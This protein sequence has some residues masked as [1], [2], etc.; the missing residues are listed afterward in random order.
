M[1]L[2]KEVSILIESMDQRRRSSEKKRQNLKKK[3]DNEKIK[4]SAKKNA[5]NISPFIKKT[6]NKSNPEEENKKKLIQVKK[7][8]YKFTHFDDEDEDW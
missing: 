5:N 2:S 3:L 8:K 6:Q 4:L 1:K 7:D